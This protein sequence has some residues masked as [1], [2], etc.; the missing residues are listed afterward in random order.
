MSSMLSN[1][2]TLNNERKRIVYSVAEGTLKV[3]VSIWTTVILTFL[4]GFAVNLATANDLDNN[5][6]KSVLPLFFTLANS[7]V[8]ALGVVALVIMGI[9][10]VATSV[11]VFITQFM[12]PPAPVIIEWQEL[13][14]QIQEDIE[15]T[16]NRE[17]NQKRAD[18]EG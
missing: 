18:E 15:A 9:V 12:K 13:V 6:K 1:N 8:T 17:K 10:I 11:A 5:F 3:A 4:V 14:K 16:E 7:H 2:T